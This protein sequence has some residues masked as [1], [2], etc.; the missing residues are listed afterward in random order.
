[1]SGVMPLLPLY[2][3]MVWRRRTFHYIW[4]P[5]SSGAS[6]PILLDLR[7]IF[8]S[9]Q[10]VKTILPNSLLDTHIS[11]IVIGHVVPNLFCLASEEE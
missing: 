8:L 3:F 7:V 1:M 10:K 9:F 11:P 5:V 6:I 4:H 2:A